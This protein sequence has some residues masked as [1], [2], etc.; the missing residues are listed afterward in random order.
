MSDPTP[1]CQMCPSFLSKDKVS[2][3]FGKS[4]GAPM[5]ARFGKVLGAPDI[6]PVAEKAL[7]ERVASD[8]KGYGMPAPKMPQGFLQTEVSLPHPGVLKEVA[9]EPSTDD[10]KVLVN[11]CMN[12]KFYVDEET[13]LEKHGW[14]AGL[15]S[16]TGRLI[17]PG[18]QS[19]EARECDY[20][21][22][23]RYNSTEYP[24]DKVHIIPMFS[25]AKDYDPSPLGKWK[26]AKKNG[27]FIDPRDYPSDFE[28]S[29]EDKES[30]I[31]AWR[32][33]EDPNGTGNVTMLPIFDPAYFSEAELSAVPQTGDVEHPED[34]IDAADYVYSVAV[35]WM[36][37]DAT[38]A[39]WGSPGTGKTELGRHIAWMMQI[40]F[41][42][43]SGTREMEV[44]D[45]IG[46]MMF[47]DGETKFQWGRLPHAWV[48]PRVILLDEPNAWPDAVWQRIR[49]LTDNSKQLVLDEAGAEVV[50]RNPFCFLLMAMNPSWDSRN[51][52]LNEIAQADT[53]RL[54][55]VYMS[56]PAREVEVEILRAACEH[57]GWTPGQEVLAGVLE[58]SDEIRA[59]VEDGS[60]PVSWGVRENLKVIRHLKWFSPAVA[61][62]RSVADFLEPQVQE[63]LLDIV[64]TGGRL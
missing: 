12:C 41:D 17:I 10:E 11:T 6:L 35:E 37:L 8:C 39:L 50:Q 31:R 24:L 33:V 3:V 4:I 1:S 61:Y 60:L 42:R 63:M 9:V 51:T 49:P 47:L 26:K 59:L 48:K 16:A 5:C 56:L 62:R 14:A 54:T 36:E 7:Q 58:N 52:G 44:E 27:S 18:R 19:R 40:P 20:R 32:R 57:D 29:D 45:L 34:Y 15:C 2:G 55:H 43:I 28:V 25:E 64:N 21:K 53:S 13:V 23:G 46:K 30:G 38:P 22:P